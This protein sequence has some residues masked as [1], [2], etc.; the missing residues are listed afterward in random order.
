MFYQ[1]FHFH[2]E[3]QLVL[4]P[5]C[6][7]KLKIVLVLGMFAQLLP[8]NNC[9]WN[10]AAVDPVAVAIVCK[11]PPENGRDI[12]VGAIVPVPAALPDITIPGVT[13]AFA[14]VNTPAATVP[15]VAVTVHVPAA[16][17][18]AEIVSVYTLYTKCTQKMNNEL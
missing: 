6:R 13:T 5:Q 15:P 9:H 10:V 18:P 17:V 7:P 4:L 16:A 2:N 3:F 8:D 12:A 14:M 1:Q 11:A